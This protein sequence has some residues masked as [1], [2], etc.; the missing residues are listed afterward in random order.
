MARTGGEKS[1]PVRDRHS[2]LNANQ[3]SN[4][5]RTANGR[6]FLEGV[7]GL[8]CGSYTANWGRTLEQPYNTWLYALAAFFYALTI[9]FVAYRL[10]PDYIKRVRFWL[11]A[12]MV[13]NLIITGVWSV[14]VWRQQAAALA[15]NQKSTSAPAPFYVTQGATISA[16]YAG[17]TS[18]LVAMVSRLGNIIIPVHLIA[19]FTIENTQ[20]VPATIESYSLEGS[21]SP[22]GPWRKLCPIS[23]AGASVYT[24]TALPPSGGIQDVVPLDF[25]KNSLEILL[26]TRRMGPHETI[27]GWAFWD[28]TPWCDQKVFRFNV[29][30]AAGLEASVVLSSPYRSAELGLQNSFF[31]LAKRDALHTDLTKP[32]FRVWNPCAPR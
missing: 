5:L 16:E 24:F 4:E 25:S 8:G 26:M 23:L 10:I 15:A 13:L 11:V 3:D 20:S 28:C 1:E 7:F 30:D 21:A 9:Y 27:S 22:N 14:H 32:S 19:F 6:L 18:P 17:I 29:R 31:P 2:K 12:A